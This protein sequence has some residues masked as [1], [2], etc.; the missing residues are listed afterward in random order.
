MN[1]IS[2][3]SKEPDNEK[4]N[5]N[6]ALD[7]F[8]VL[9]CLGVIAYH[10]FDDFL[11][12]KIVTAFYFA[13]GFCIPG[14]FLLS[15]Y[16]LA[17]HGKI[18]YEYVEKKLLNICFKWLGWFVLYRV[19]KYIFVGYYDA[20]LYLYVDWFLFT[21]CIIM[22]LSPLLL[23]F[24]NKTQWIFSIT[25]IVS[26]I[27]LNT[28]CFDF[29]YD[30]RPQSTWFHLYLPYFMLG[31]VLTK[32]TKFKL[33][34]KFTSKIMMFFIF[35]ALTA[36]YLYTALTKW[37]ALGLPP[38]MNYSRWYYALWLVSLFLFIFFA[39]SHKEFQTSVD[40]ASKAAGDKGIKPAHPHVTHIISRFAKDTFG[41]WLSH[42]PIQV[43]LFTHFKIDRSILVLLCLPLV[44][45]LA[46]VFVE[47]LRL[48]PITR[49]IV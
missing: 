18:T 34:Q 40:I 1:S 23:Q 48:F 11:S 19:L 5:R 14:F 44:F 36:L 2:F 47:I 13:A 30:K 6:I 26:F 45:I 35:I 41:I 3:N 9:C 22:I 8:R 10:T 21:Y 15:G 33:L 46:F 32:I 31:M 25:V 49:R 27:I 39:F 24:L 4:N 16:L 7:I 28:G 37:Y 12:S 42:L 43:F 20:N 38:H 17:L 29:L